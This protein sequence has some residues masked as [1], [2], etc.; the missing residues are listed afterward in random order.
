MSPRL[1]G[2]IFFGAITVAAT[3]MAIGTFVN[4]SAVIGGIVLCFAATVAWVTIR[5]IRLPK[6]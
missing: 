6:G 3:Y 5:A 4:G 1:Q 2:I